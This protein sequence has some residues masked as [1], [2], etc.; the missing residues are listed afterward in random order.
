MSGYLDD[1]E[2]T[3]RVLT[4]GWLHTGDLA[5]WDE[6]GRLILDGREDEL[7]KLRDGRRFHPRELESVLEGLE[8]VESAAATLS[9]ESQGIVALLVSGRTAES[10]R[11]EVSAL[12]PPHLV[13]A[14][15]W[16]VPALPRNSNGKLMRSELAGMLAE[17]VPAQQA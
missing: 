15:I 6:S 2:G 7:L 16:I 9:R 8:R 14:E 5:H 11:E 10:I 3:A 13:P 4:G 12:V 1:P 17:R